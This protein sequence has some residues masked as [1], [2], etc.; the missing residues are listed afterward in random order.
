MCRI[1]N[2]QGNST[3]NKH[4]LKCHEGS[5]NGWLSPALPQ[6]LSEDTPLETG[7]LTSEQL[8]WVGSINA[9]SGIFGTFVFGIVTAYLGCKRAMILLSIPCFTFWTLIYV[10]NTY[11]HVLIA[12]FFMGTTGGGIQTTVILYISEIS[13]NEYDDISNNF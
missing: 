7:P 9:L 5:M 1:S 11:Y 2:C 4:I 13:N 8:S 12:R 10:G 6:L 3:S